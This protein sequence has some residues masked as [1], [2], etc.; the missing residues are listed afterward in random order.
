MVAIAADKAVSYWC[1]KQEKKGKPV[2]RDAAM[3]VI[4]NSDFI[5]GLV[6]NL[7]YQIDNAKK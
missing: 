1:D 3:E 7:G 6:T 5:T 4:S 2:D